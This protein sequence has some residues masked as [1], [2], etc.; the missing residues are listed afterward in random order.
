MFDRVSYVDLSKM[1]MNRNLPVD[2]IVA[3]EL[4]RNLWLM[5]RTLVIIT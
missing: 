1:C 5:T 4:F 2:G 3:M